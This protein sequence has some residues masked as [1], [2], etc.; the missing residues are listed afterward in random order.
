MLL[1]EI[2]STKYTDEEYLKVQRKRHATR[3]QRIKN[4]I[5]KRK[6]DAEYISAMRR[7]SEYAMK[8]MF[9]LPGTNGQHL[10][11]GTPPAWHECRTD[12]EEYLWHL[13]RT[14][15]F[16][17]LTELYILTG[18][19]AYAEKT[20][21]DISDWIDNCP[22]YPLPTAIATKAE[23]EEL[24]KPYWNVTPWRSLEVGIRVFDSWNHLY[25]TLLDTELMTPSLHSKLAV[26]FFEH[27]QV[28]RIM[29]P[30]F[31]PNANHNHYIHEM[32]G[33]LN[34]VCLFPDFNKADELREFATKEIIR[35]V[36]NQF[37]EC[38]GHI[39]GTPSYHEISLLMIYDVIKLANDF[40]LTLP[41][42]VTDICKKATEYELYAVCPN[43]NMASVGDSPMRVGGK[44]TTVSYYKS[45]GELGPCANIFGIHTDFDPLYIPPETQKEARRT[46][47]Q[48]SGGYNYQR[49][50]GQY[51]ARTGWRR[52]DSHF[53]FLCGTPFFGSHAHQDPMSFILTLNGDPVVIDPS[54]FTY[55]ECPERKLFKSPEY[56]SCLTFDGKP[57]FE[58]IGRWNYGP[59]K[60]GSIRKTYHSDGIYAADASHHNYD[61]DFHKRL[62]AL[63]GDDIF[64]VA[65][66]VVNVTGTD[67]RIY[68]HMDDPLLKLIDGNAVSSRIRV[69]LPKGVDAEIVASEKSPR[70]D[71]KEPSSRI[72]LTDRN[73]GNATYLTVFTKRGDVT[74]PEIIRINDGLRISYKVGGKE[75]AFLWSFSS[76]FEKLVI[77]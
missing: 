18:E 16:K 1:N 37:T 74:E 67:V 63:V 77:D 42:Y 73:H 39:E 30:I 34:T 28:L 64:I 61:P 60:E 8:N 62:C 46:A 20:I 6:S 26:S 31:W 53:M 65:D 56:H 22:M 27:A 44:K 24:K 51:I 69:L 11:V 12:D 40:G 35:C 7:E 5:L 25:D 59:Q 4:E 49:Q 2:L 43:G 50:L 13:N 57:P 71:I 52:T 76:R 14:S 9:V 15:W 3:C 17:P 21:A 19:R 54:F 48:S 55:R 38:G 33:L 41:E 10:H 36:K 66:D 47:E 68:F 72:I 45:F 58:Y 29:S 23:L 32:L 75:K 70:G